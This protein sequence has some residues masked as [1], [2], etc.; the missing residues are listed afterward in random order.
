M[1][2]YYAKIILWLWVSFLPEEDDFSFSFPQKKVQT[3]SALK[4]WEIKS[5]SSCLRG[6]LGFPMTDDIK[7][8][9]EEVLIL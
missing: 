3:S 6:F 2:R 1:F 4:L 5:R 9:R 7:S 8:G